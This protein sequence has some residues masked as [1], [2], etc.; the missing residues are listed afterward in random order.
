MLVDAEH[1]HDRGLGG[2][3][4]LGVEVRAQRGG[5][6]VAGRAG[7]ADV[8]HDP[9]RV[10]VPRRRAGRSPRRRRRGS[11]G[12]RRS[13]RPCG[14][15]RRSCRASSAS[16][17]STSWRRAPSS[18]SIS[19]DDGDVERMSRSVRAT[20]S[21]SMR[22]ESETCSSADWVSEPAILCTDVSIASAPSVQRARR[23][24]AVEA[25]VRAPRLVDDQR[26][27]GG[28]RDLRAARDVGRHP[29]VGGGD[30]ERGARARGGL[31]RGAA[32][33]PASRRAPCRARARTAA[34][35]RSA[36]RRTAPARRSPTRARC[37]ARRPARPAAPA[38]G[39]ARGCPGWRRWSETTSAQRRRP[40]RRAPPRARTAS[41]D[42]PRST[43][44]MSCGMSSLSVCQPIAV[45][46]PRSA[47]LPALW[48]GTW[49]RVE[50]RN[51]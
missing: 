12:S 9:Q 23:Q 49:K 20:A 43:P 30:D 33:S 26:H 24:V 6:R 29:V 17:C 8:D 46:T 35:P 14:A 15:R 39:T 4:D 5:H 34:A 10:A 11:R 13:P 48:P 50:P 27:A 28:V 22:P 47:P 7:A 37:A 51:P 45:R 1:E 32:A 25:E 21:G 41:G 18:D 31:Q 42:S 16:P 38:P 40:R 36:G 3:L 44:W 19:S 2:E